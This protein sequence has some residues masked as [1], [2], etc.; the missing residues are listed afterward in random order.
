MPTVQAIISTPDIERQRAFYERLLGA[1][2]TNRFPADG[3][4][5][6]VDLTLG[7]SQFGL[8]HEAGTDLSAPARILLSVEV[9]DVDVL[10][11]R[12]AAAG[13]RVLGKANDMPWGQRVA[14]IHDPDGNMVNLTQTLSS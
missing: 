14:H 13:G 5:F 2:P 11:E 3:P 10:L 8:V 4:A 1:V 6:S 9:D 12:V 7:D